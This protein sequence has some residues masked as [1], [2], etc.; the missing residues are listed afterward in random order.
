MH[1]E[2]KDDKQDFTATIRMD[3]DKKIWVSIVALGL[4]EAA[5]ALI[6]P[7]SII[8]I[9]RL[10]KEV[11]MLAFKDAGK[12]LP[13]NVDFATLQSLL[14]GEALHVS[15]DRPTDASVLAD[16]LMLAVKNDKYA[17][18]LSY[19]KDSTVRNQQLKVLGDK[20]A[21][22]DMQYGDYMVTG[23]K[24]FANN[25]IINIQDATGMYHIE[26]DFSRADFNQDLDFSFSV[27]TKY[28][29]K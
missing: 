25:R 17:Q 11:K 28:T 26:M 18:Q 23:D 13:V 12:L 15:T 19:S 8:V 4:F 6:T 27:P 14:I 9:D 22:I 2:G 1:Y 5:R 24:H 16:G 7:D 20:G 21:Q 3:K 29:R 10:H